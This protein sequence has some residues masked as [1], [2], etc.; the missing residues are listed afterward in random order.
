MVGTVVC[1]VS[2]D[3][4]GV[5]EM[6]GTSSSFLENAD[7]DTIVHRTTVMK[8]P[9]PSEMK[10]TYFLVSAYQI[11]VNVLSKTLFP[12]HARTTARFL[13]VHLT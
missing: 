11:L 1:T 4:I 2:T 13:V 7:D 3:R 12:L 9:T 8:K 5:V 10:L 6:V